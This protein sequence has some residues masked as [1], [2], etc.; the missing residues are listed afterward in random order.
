MDTAASAPAAI[1]PMEEQNTGVK[2]SKETAAPKSKS[3]AK[4]KKDEIVAT[5]SP[6]SLPPPP[7][8]GAAALRATEE[9][10]VEPASASSANAPTS[11]PHYR[12]KEGSAPSG[13]RKKP[14]PGGEMI[15][16][17]PAV[18]VKRKGEKPLEEGIPDAL[19]PER[20]RPR[21]PLAEPD[22]EANPMQS[23][24][25]SSSSRR[26]ANRNPMKV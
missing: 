18:P 19:R 14:P 12:Q 13:Y 25:S 21:A 10:D 3:K 24:S 2:R 1:V 6:P 16:D 9:P 26:L 11:V 22:P 15:D 5:Q 4:K 8:G 20:Q 23:S 7:P 17:L